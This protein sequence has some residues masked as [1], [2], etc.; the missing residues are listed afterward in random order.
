MKMNPENAD[1]L[2]NA[3]QSAENNGDRRRQR[4][5]DLLGQLFARYWLRSQPKQ[6]SHGEPPAKEEGAQS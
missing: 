1:P 2:P 5:A 4:L 3:T 6:S